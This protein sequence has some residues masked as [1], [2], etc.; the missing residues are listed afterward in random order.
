MR[1]IALRTLQRL[2]AAKPLIVA[3]DSGH[4]AAHVAWPAAIVTAFIPSGRPA[5]AG[6]NVNLIDGRA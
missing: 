1:A 3:T 2:D 5:V 6:H 4:I